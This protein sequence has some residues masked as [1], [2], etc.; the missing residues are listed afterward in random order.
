LPDP[1][2]AVFNFIMT[3]LSEE[4]EMGDAK[5]LIRVMDVTCRP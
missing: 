2:R 3:G 4:G 5:G 1:G